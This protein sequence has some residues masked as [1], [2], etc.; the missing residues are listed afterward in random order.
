MKENFTEYLSN[1]NDIWDVK[2]KNYDKL[3]NILPA[4]KRIIVIGDIHG[5]LP[6]LLQC[7]NKAK[8]IDYKNNWIGKDTI[9]VQVGDQ[10]DSCRFNGINKCMDPDTHKV[11]FTNDM[12]HD[13]IILKFMTQLHYKALQKGGAVYSL[14]GN[15]ELMNVMGD[16]TY[17]SHKNVN[18]FKNYKLPDGTVIEDAM[19]ARKYIFSPGNDI[20]NFLA[21]SRQ[22]A[23]IIGSNLFVHAGIVPEISTKYKIEDL[24][25][26][27]TLFLLNELKN[28][29]I[30]QDLFIS[31]KLS[32]L[33]TRSFG[34]DKSLN[35]C[36]ELMSP[37]KSLYKVGR[38]VVGHTP[39]LKHGINNICNK[40]VYLVDVGMPEAFNQFDEIKIKTGIKSKYRTAQVLEILN[41]GE[42]INILK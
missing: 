41:D 23:L 32:P 22:S 40:E 15:H 2:C 12:A 33:W 35:E 17:V 3:P 14:L 13:I 42:I 38:I 37:L 11:N 5:D 6:I 16:M 30:F 34:Y 4:A 39:Q 25:K 27:I 26:L 20:A 31:S 10:I 19:T 18:Q 1:F 24:N 7:L 8:V 9:I 28:P 29:N 21:C 36:D